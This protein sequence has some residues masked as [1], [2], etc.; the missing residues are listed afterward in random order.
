MLGQNHFVDPNWHISTSNLDVQGRTLSS[1][2][3]ALIIISAVNRS[4][5][6]AGA[7]D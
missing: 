3:D 1:A 5:G 7:G 4:C 2:I 6:A